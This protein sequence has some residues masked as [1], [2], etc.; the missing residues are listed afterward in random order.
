ME[1]TCNPDYFLENSNVTFKN[2]FI[3]AF[4]QLFHDLTPELGTDFIPWDGLEKVALKP[5]AKILVTNTVVVDAIPKYFAGIELNYDPESK[6]VP[7][8]NITAPYCLP[9]GCW[10]ICAR[11]VP[12]YTRTPY[13][14]QEDDDEQ[15][16]WYTNGK[17]S[18]GSEFS[19]GDI[20][21]GPHLRELRTIMV[22]FIINYLRHIK[23]NGQYNFYLDNELEKSG[24]SKEV[25]TVIK[26]RVRQSQIECLHFF[27]TVIGYDKNTYKKIKS[28]MKENMY[29]DYT[30]DDYY[31]FGYMNRTEYGHEDQPP[32]RQQSDDEGLITYFRGWGGDYSEQVIMKEGV[33][34]GEE[35]DEDEGEEELMEYKGAEER[36]D[37]S[38]SSDVGEND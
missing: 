34:E 8:Y 27:E 26:D 6:T 3:E 16:K 28:A 36:S 10:L 20:E 24:H 2:P 23:L 30:K 9:V 21:M 38:D 29:T 17:K 31:G 35:E 15:R 18:I 1:N 33:G 5:V 37:S 32:K 7:P 14:F 19:I 4:K 11:R 25:Q 13:P 12:L 22:Y